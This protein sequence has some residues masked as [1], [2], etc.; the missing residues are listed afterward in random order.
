M[1][2]AGFRVVICCIS[3]GC[4]L[5][6]GFVGVVSA[7]GEELVVICTNSVLADFAT[8]VIGDQF[9][10][11][12][13]VEFIMPAGACPSHFDASPSDAVM[14]ASA[15]VVISLGWEPWLFDLLESSGNDDVHKISCLGLV[16]WNLPTGAESHLV[17]I[18]EGMSEFLPEWESA[19]EANAFNY[20]AEIV[21]SFEAAR[22]RVLSEGLNGTK[23]ISIDW[24]AKFLEWL[25]FEVVETYGAPESLSTADVLEIHDACNDPEVAMVVDNLQSTVD[26]GSQLA[27][28]YGKSHVILSNFPGGIP[29]RYTYL[30]NIEYNFDE[31]V[32]GAVAYEM[33]QSELSD[34]ESEISSLE[35]QRLALASLV[36][37]LVFL[38][39][40]FIILARRKRQ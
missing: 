29:G 31:V 32:N 18:A 34:L 2:C 4:L 11:T 6:V 33:T 1:K 5:S 39:A 3:A 30:D 8:N 24:H 16:E 21:N 10:D 37:V 35:F 22:L 27:A 9:S 20:T 15:D 40:L 23:V 7:E 13:K 12:L 38:L 26:F 36:A 25:G 14:I 28:D 19:F 17:R